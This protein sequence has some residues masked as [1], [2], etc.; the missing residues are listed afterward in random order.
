MTDDNTLQELEQIIKNKK[1]YQI[2]KNKTT[3][4]LDIDNATIGDVADVLATL[5]TDLKQQRIIK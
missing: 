4:H 2:K 1:P 3:R 5:I